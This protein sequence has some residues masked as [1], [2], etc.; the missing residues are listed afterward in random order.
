M[1]QTIP[2]RLAAHID[3]TCGLHNTGGVSQFFDDEGNLRACQ[4]GESVF[5]FTIACS[6]VQYEEAEHDDYLMNVW[7]MIEGDISGLK[8][9]QE[10]VDSF[11]MP[12]PRL[13]V[14]MKVFWTDPDED[15]C[16]GVFIIEKIN[17]ETYSLGNDVGSEIEALAHELEEVTA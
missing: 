3:E 1:A 7:N 8:H 5:A 2:Q 16:S 4:P 13:K 10:A 17:G 12:E 9:V 6:L 11:K 15:K 14:G